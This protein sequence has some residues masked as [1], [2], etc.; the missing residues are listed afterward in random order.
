MTE[1]YN[2]TPAHPDLF[3]AI[4][5]QYSE[6]MFFESSDKIVDKKWNLGYSKLNMQ[7]TYIPLRHVTRVPDTLIVMKGIPLCDFKSHY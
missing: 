4:S 5:P 6:S 1:Y 3:N 7:R 2:W